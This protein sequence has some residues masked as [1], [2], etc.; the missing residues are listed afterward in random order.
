M[1]ELN[2]R[3]QSGVSKPDNPHT[4]KVGQNGLAITCAKAMVVLNKVVRYTFSYRS[5]AVVSKAQNPDQVW[6][7]IN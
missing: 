3:S 6:T 5:L 1:I 7:H 4:V 2:I